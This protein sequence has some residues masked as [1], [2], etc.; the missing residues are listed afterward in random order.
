MECAEKGKAGPTARLFVEI[1]DSGGIVY[2]GGAIPNYGFCKSVKR[3]E[4]YLYFFVNGLPA[5][6]EFGSK[7]F[8]GGCPG[9]A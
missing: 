1:S 4:I 2:H 3:R 6:L 9:S 5:N 7:G 8:S